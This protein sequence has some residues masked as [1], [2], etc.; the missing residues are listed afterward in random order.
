MPILANVEKLMSILDMSDLVI[1]LFKSNGFRNQKEKEEI[2]PITVLLLTRRFTIRK[3][4]PF[5]FSGE[6]SP[7]NTWDGEEET[8][9]MLTSETGTIGTIME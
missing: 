3:M 7:E 6:T 8:M 4:K 1:E 5:L 2:S 9:V